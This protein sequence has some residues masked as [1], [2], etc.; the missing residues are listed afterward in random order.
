MTVKISQAKTTKILHLYFSGMPQLKIA[1]K[2]QIDQTTVSRCAAE[3]KKDAAVKGIDK[4]AEE[5][6]IME[7]IVGLR[8]I[9]TELYKHKTG[10]EDAMSGLAM[11]KLFNSLGVSPEEYKPL[12]KAV[13]KVKDSDYIKVAMNLAKLEESTGKTY[14]D[15]A[16]EYQQLGE[17]IAGRQKAI[18]T[19][20]EKQEKEEES[21]EKLEL[22][23][24]EKEAELAEAQKGTEQKKAAADAEVDKKLAEAALTLEKVAKVHPVVEKLNV[25]GIP[26]DDFE[27][28]VEEH[29]VLEEQGI[30]W[31][32][33]QTVAGAL[34]KSKDINGDNLTAK[35]AEY[36][37]LDQ[38]ISSMKAE[39]A[40]LQ[41]EVEILGRNKIKLTAEV[42]GLVKSKAQLETEV[43]HLEGSKKALD[44]TIET[45]K[46]RRDH[47]EKHVAALESDVTNLTAKKAALTEEA[48]KKELEVSEMNKQLNEADAISQTLMKKQV[49]FQELEIKKAA[50]G[51]KFGMFEAFLGLVSERSEAKIEE[52][53]KFVPTLIKEA[54]TGN[55][56]PGFLVDIVLGQLSGSTLDQ[57]GCDYCGAE[58]VMLKRRQKAIQGSGLTEKTPMRCPD[59]GESLKT[60][61]KT[62]LGSTL[63]KVI[64]TGIPTLKKPGATSSDEENLAGP[65]AGK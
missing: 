36:G 9:A 42:D 20:K 17:E 59:C 64:I 56:D 34:A 27:T 15:V 60:V 46:G 4:A 65:E 16:S 3:F 50:A 6:G 63:K 5:R 33:F 55:Y 2:C 24:K 22:A 61:V 43:G 51:Q 58:F 11:V 41:P 7:E 44:D 25:L 23:R 48:S 47:L 28:F 26:D 49:E 38:S 14:T 30:T 12:A 21:L 10:V 54:K 35:L 62:P 19:L 37:T 1:A 53:L 8:S 45:L 57:L 39:K 52:F 29:Q 13:S 32:K 31:E 40:S 18:A